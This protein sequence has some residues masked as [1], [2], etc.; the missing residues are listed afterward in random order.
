MSFRWLGFTRRGSYTA[1][2]KF[3]LEER[4][5]IKSRIDSIDRQ[6]YFL[7]EVLVTYDTNEDGESIQKP[8]KFEVLGDK[9]SIAKL[10]KA[11]I[12]LG[13]NPL[14]ISMFLNPMD[15]RIH[16]TDESIFFE[17]TAMG[18][19]VAPMS[20]SP[21]QY[22]YTGGYYEWES[23]PKWNLGNA[24]LTPERTYWAM[25]TFLKSRKWTE[26]EIR[27]K[28]NKLEEKIIKL[29]DLAEQLQKE[30]DMLLEKIESFDDTLHPPDIFNLQQS[31]EYPIALVDNVFWKEE[32]GKDMPKASD[33]EER[34]LTEEMLALGRDE[35]EQNRDVQIRT[36]HMN[37]FEETEN[38]KY[39]ITAL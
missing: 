3:I 8:K 37:L 25:E 7:G 36:H 23:D 18:G 21:D 27:N 6:I 17:E 22:A 28:R 2:R 15:T 31:A 34:K 13:G 11:Y 33:P 4:R 24:E 32:E 12:S 19:V 30:K 35:L 5:D 10:V 29:C 39:P 1:F 9:G 16:K 26:K 14:D 38:Q 20:G